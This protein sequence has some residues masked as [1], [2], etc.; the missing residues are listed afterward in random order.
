M[1]PLSRRSGPL[2]TLSLTAGCPRRRGGGV[3][4]GLDEMTAAF[5][6]RVRDLAAR[7]GP[8]L[9]CLPRGSGG[10]LAAAERGG[11]RRR[12]EEDERALLL[13]R[14]PR[15]PREPGLQPG[16]GSA[17]PGGTAAGAGEDV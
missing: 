4:N 11:L 7:P 13:H 15:R 2:W 3:S 14:P 5:D 6:P 12:T 9:R 8:H 1:G 10:A 17:R 16:R